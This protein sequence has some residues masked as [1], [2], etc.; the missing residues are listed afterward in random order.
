MTS[1]YKIIG[2]VLLIAF[3]CNSN[4]QEQPIL[5]NYTHNPLTINPAIAGTVKGLNMNFLTRQQWVGIEGYPASY[6]FGAHTPYPE[7][8]F[9]LGFNLMTERVGPVKNTEIKAS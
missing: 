5:T 1:K 2:L 3:V 8:D 7:F 9:G 6:S 4:A